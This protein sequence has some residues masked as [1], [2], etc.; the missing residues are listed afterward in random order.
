MQ[1]LFDA[2]ITPSE[3]LLVQLIDTADR[4]VVVLLFDTRVRLH[5]LLEDVKNSDATAGW[6]WSSWPA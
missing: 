6:R 4:G 2:K 3:V 5:S 1:R